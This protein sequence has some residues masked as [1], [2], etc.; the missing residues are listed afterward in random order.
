M[1]VSPSR[2]VYVCAS[3]PG[4]GKSLVTLGLVDILH[5]HADKV[6]FFRPI[7]NT[8]D[9]EA[10]PMV[11]MLRELYGLQD[12][13]CCGGIGLAEAG[14]LLAAGRGEEIETEAVARFSMIAK[15]CDVVVVDG[16]DLR[17]H[18][19]AAEFTLNAHLANTLG[20]P[21]V[22]VVGADGM[23]AAETVDAVDV[24]RK[25]LA[26]FHC[27]LLAVMVNR[28]D[29][30]VSAETRRT[31]HPGVSGRP[32]YVIPE[33]AEIARPTVNDV[34]L[35]LGLAQLGGDA[36]LD[37]DVRAVKVAAMTV[38][39]FLKE[40]VA[41]DLVIVPGD[42]A[43]VMVASLAC[44][45][46]PEFPVPSGMIPTD[47][48]A[49]DPSVLPLL[50]RAPFPVFVDGH[51][52]YTTAHKVAG[53][54]GEIHAGRRRKVA[55]ALGA[56]SRCVDEGELLERLAV[57]RPATMTPLRFLNDLIERA[58]NQRRRI[59]LAE[60]TEPRVLRA[61]EILH[62][63]DVCDLTVLGNEAIT[64]ELSA[65]L[66]IDLAGVDIV[67]PATSELRE[68]FA[69]EYQR[70]R[71]HK[72]VGP[73]RAREAM[74]EGA[75]FGTMMVHLGLADGMVSGAAHTTADT[76][77]PA[78]E[79][80]G[81]GVGVRSVSSVFFMLFPDRVLVYG[82]CAVIPVPTLEQLA[83]IA[84][85]SAATA[86][87]FG[88][89]P[90]VAMLS[91]ST[92]ISG[93]GRSVD[94]V[95]RATELVRSARPDLAVDGPLQYDAA[96]DAS[97]ARLKRQTS[98]VA[99]AATVLIFPDLNTGNNTYKAVEQSSGAIAVGP[100]LQG[101]RKPIN[102]LSRGSTVDDIV[103][104]VAIT[105]VQAQ[106]DPDAWQPEGWDLGPCHLRTFPT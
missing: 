85:A 82:D 37:R 74:L 67:D 97:I 95:R 15:L 14:K 106:K 90:K 44:G 96:V 35:A 21:V 98:A 102:D 69:G 58:R 72:A 66:G 16:S 22:A 46:S 48:L 49:P 13:V 63:R 100:I 93:A 80:I 86:V 61:A 47:G 1:T 88:V 7:V 89:D 50:D 45:Y 12:A 104:T 105:A 38:G 4:A 26:S 51:D 27:S 39:N 94:L 20:L 101:L 43:D 29:A 84:I 18:D 91:Y 81:T 55:A 10:D 40:L 3:T 60:G 30:G 77:R 99:G 64:R 68:R 42:R 75:Y 17:G 83:D 78:L 9:P 23:G 25:Q 6:G 53:V 79:F 87:Q 56:W 19:V 2:G 8:A 5:R 103:N 71:A 65:A 76:I 52:T 41:G 62:R 34:S 33:T 32:V 31:M 57:P 54:R 24:T 70:L 11:L 59:V 28:A 73:A 36:E 92:G